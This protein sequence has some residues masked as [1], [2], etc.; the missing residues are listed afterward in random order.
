MRKTIMFGTLIVLF[1]AG[2]LA[3]A[4]DVTATEPT[5]AVEA[6]KPDAP[7]VRSEAT[8]PKRRA[9]SHEEHREGQRKHHDE[10]RESRDERRKHDRH[11]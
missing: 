1:G 3:Q 8:A 9:A 5:N 11:H 10:V 2:A 7:A 6:A 4:K